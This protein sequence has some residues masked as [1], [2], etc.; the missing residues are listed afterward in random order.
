MG[1]CMRAVKRGGNP[2][3]LPSP[4]RSANV[5]ISTRHDILHRI[6]TRPNRAPRVF[7][8]PPHPT[9]VVQRPSSVLHSHNTT[10]NRRPTIKIS[11]PNNIYLLCY[12]AFGLACGF[13]SNCF[14]ILLRPAA[15]TRIRSLNFFSGLFLKAMDTLGRFAPT[16]YSTTHQYFTPTSL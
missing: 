7:R 10:T 12:K 3:A 6:Q 5:A 16:R 15:P 2:P 1:R 4:I 8:V 13:Y 9:F 11:T 14:T